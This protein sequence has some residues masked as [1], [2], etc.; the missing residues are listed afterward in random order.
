MENPHINYSAES[1]YGLQIKAVLAQC[2]NF[3]TNCDRRK[4][5]KRQMQ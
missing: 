3:S 4:T 5:F 2:K 1:R